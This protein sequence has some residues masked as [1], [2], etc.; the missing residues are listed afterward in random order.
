MNNLKLKLRPFIPSGVY[1]GQITSVEGNEE[2]R[3]IVI[4]FCFNGKIEPIE[5]IMVLDADIPS[6]MAL[7]LNLINDG[8]IYF[9][10]SFENVIGLWLTIVVER[11]EE[12]RV[13]MIF[14]KEMYNKCKKNEKE[15]LEYLYQSRVHNY[16]Q[17]S[18]SVNEDNLRKDGSHKGYSELFDNIL[19]DMILYQKPDIQ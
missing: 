12:L 7:H 9:E 13:S 6:Q 3:S 18:F 15:I 2:A 1:L 19:E 17:A 11:H 10:N 8:C 5:A 16:V 4:K 14:P